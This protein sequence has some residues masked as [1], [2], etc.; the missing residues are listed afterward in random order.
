MASQQ[1][2]VQS[3]TLD[4][5]LSVAA[6]ASKSQT[7]EPQLPD[8]DPQP[9]RRQDY[10]LP[11]LIHA[12]KVLRTWQQNTVTEIQAIRHCISTHARRLWYF[13]NSKPTL[14]PKRD[15]EFRN[16]LHPLVDVNDLKNELKRAKKGTTG[17]L[18]TVDELL[19]L[20]DEPLETSGK[21][22]DF[23]HTH[24]GMK[25][26]HKGMKNHCFSRKNM[27]HTLKHLFINFS[28]CFIP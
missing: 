28:V 24:K 26:T 19:A 18:T 21:N 27:F 25:Q 6:N 3:E 13:A 2:Q 20:P 5:A 17:R 9:I 12:D 15:A 4:I 1:K 10:P 23:F 8:W 16:I 14:M 22:S 7:H 11:I